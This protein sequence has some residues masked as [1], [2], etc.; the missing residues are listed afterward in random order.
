MITIKISYVDFWWEKNSLR[1]LV[2]YD[3]GIGLFH[4]DT[5]KKNFPHIN[6]ILTDPNSSDLLIT[7]TFGINKYQEK[8]KIILAYESNSGM[9]FKNQNKEYIFSSYVLNNSYNMGLSFLYKGFDYYNTLK[10]Q[11]IM[12]PKTKF[13]IC[14]ISNE[15]A[16]FRKDF[17]E[18]LMEYKMVDCYGI[19]FKN[20]SNPIIETTNWHDNNIYEVIQDYKFM[21]CMENTMKENYWTEKLVNGYS[22]NTIPIYWGDV[23]INDVF[24]E[25]SFININK[26]GVEKGIDLIKMLDCDYDQYNEMFMEPLISN[27][28]YEKYY[29]MSYYKNHMN[30][31]FN[32][33][34]NEKIL[35]TQFMENTFKT[36]LVIN[37]DRRKDRYDE[38]CMHCPFDS[39]II[40]RISG[41]D[42]KNLEE[43]LVKQYKMERGAIG[44]F[45]SHLNAWKTITNNNMHDSD[46]SIIFEDDIFFG[47]R[48]NTEIYNIM[49]DIN[50]NEP[51]ILYIS[52]R[53]QKDFTSEYIEHYD[54]I[55]TNLYYRKKNK[56]YSTKSNGWNCH[57]PNIMNLMNNIDRCNSCII[58]NKLAAKKLTHYIDTIP[59]IAIDALLMK[60]NQ[61]TNII[62]FYDYFPHLCWSPRD[63]KSDIRI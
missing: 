42:G 22:G 48:F 19:L 61:Y 1:E 31:I 14:I 33:V 2:Y 51:F 11:R 56:Y 29:D 30:N 32:R 8:I 49:N 34:N 53:F 55:N 45:M 20:C 43:S 63:Y 3:K 6:F 57:I 12:K 4:I 18:K 21:I 26:L 58:M 15:I 47:D 59:D 54:M 40:T 37:L 44:C 25:K 27:N 5:I 9:Y 28:K 35:L 62:K 13:C 60:I 36:R 50:K 16:S 24:N 7:S 41:I 17:I 23:N 10:E 38:F 46:V 39:S 52:G